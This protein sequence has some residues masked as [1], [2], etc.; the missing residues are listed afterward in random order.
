MSVGA[1]EKWVC[2]N[3]G[4]IYDPQKGAPGGGIAPGT[5]F[6]DLPDSW[7]CPLC[8]ARKHQFDRL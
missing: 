1:P 5:R 2:I 3:C 4:Y 7:Q 8:Y 6:E